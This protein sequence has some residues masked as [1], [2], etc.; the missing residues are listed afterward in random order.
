MLVFYKRFL[1][2]SLAAVC[3]FLPTFAAAFGFAD[4]QE[5]ARELASQDYKAPQPVPEFLQK[6]S[7]D[8]F[9]S[10]RFNPEESLWRD[11]GSKFQ[12]MLMSP[13]LYFKHAVK[14]NIIDAEGV[15]DLAFNKNFFSTDD[16]NLRKRLP[17]DLGYAGFKLT[18]PINQAD[19]QDQFLV[20]AGASYFRGVGKGDRFGISARGAALDTGLMSGEEFPDFVEFW[21]ERPSK[22]SGQMKI[23]GLLNSPRL[24]GAYE[25]VVNP[26]DST[27]L[28]VRATLFTR[29]RIELVGVA[30]LTSMFYYGENT[31]RPAGNWRPEVHDSDGLLIHNGTGEWLWNPLNN[32][33]S[34]HIQSFYVDNAKGFGLVQRD[35]AFA[36]YEDT[37][38]LYEQRPST[39]VTSKG[40]W[41]EGRVVLVEI[42][43]P[44]ETNDNIVAFWSPR[45]PVAGGEEMHFSYSLA[46]GADPLPSQTPGRAVN[47]FLGRGDIMGGGDEKGAYRI[48]VDFDGGALEGLNDEAP[49]AIDASGQ[50]GTEILEHYVS[51]VPGVDRWRLSLLAKP[52]DGK[53][54]ALRAALSLDGEPVTE[55]WTYTL[56]SNNDIRDAQ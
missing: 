37:E 45:E 38:A 49:L 11:A 40:D 25:F 50:A 17:A 4:V 54:L 53:A 8:E 24:A 27:V 43:T 10:I 16:E 55:T 44:D 42:P 34:L 7:Y 29:D 47:S 30:P 18:F 19:L 3:C 41:G 26:G 52:A 33:K 31:A 46:F 13:G 20:F 6:L 5:K 1:V 23:Y 39:W 12:V 21:L 35:R 2:V 9:R 22:N 32:P 36:S 51:Y 14:I 48:V 15:H 28:D 56:L